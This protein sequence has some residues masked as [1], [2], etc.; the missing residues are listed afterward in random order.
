MLAWRDP[1]FEL[2]EC[3][4]LRRPEPI[5]ALGGCGAEAGEVLE[6]KRLSE[7]MLKYEKRSF[8]CVLVEVFP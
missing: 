6:Q 2:G 5:F 8:T 7:Y 4:L 3:L 1:G